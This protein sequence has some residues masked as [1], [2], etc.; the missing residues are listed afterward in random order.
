MKKSLL[1]VLI[2][3]LLCSFVLSSCN[4]EEQTQLIESLQESIYELEQENDRLTK[5]NADK[6]TELSTLKEELA[7]LQKEISDLESKDAANLAK[8]SE[9]N[10]AYNAKVAEL[11]SEKNAN[12]SALE[13]LEAEYTAAV[14][15]LE[16]ENATL[17]GRI[18]ELEAQVEELINKEDAIT[19][20]ANGYIVVNGVKTEYEVEVS[21]DHVW[22]TT[23]TPPTCTEDGWD[24]MTC[25]FCGKTVRTNIIEATLHKFSTNYESDNNYHWL[26]C[27]VCGEM[28][29]QAFHTL[30]DEGICTVCRL[31]I[32]STPGIVYAISTDGTYAE[33]VGYEGT[34]TKIKIADTYENLPVKVVCKNAF[35]G[36]LQ[37]IHVS[38]GSNIT[39]IELFAFKNCSN[40]KTVDFPNGLETIAGDAFYNAGLTAVTIP[41]TV[42]TLGD[43]AFYN[44]KLETV[45]IEEGVTHVSYPAFYGNY[46]L[47]NITLPNSITSIGRIA[48]GDPK[49][50]SNIQYS[51][52]N[53]N[54][55]LGNDDNPYL[56]LMYCG[57]SSGL[58][59]K[60][61]K[62]IAYGAFSNVNITSIIIPSKVSNISS[63]AFSGCD[64]L[65]IVYFEGTEFEWDKIEVSSGNSYLVNATIY[66]YSEN[67]PNESGNYWHYINGIPTIWE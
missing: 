30:N 32:S 20:D 3:S 29:S 50:S 6:D 40:L 44:C 15:S 37:I 10:V 13:A 41:G 34:A 22:N 36:N 19:V 60:D 38:F 18:A 9:L 67:K 58:I 42:K 5:E 43:C 17:N 8:I 23:T 66:Y 1:L 2:L 57:N 12:A 11:E 63:S 39:T 46:Y 61:T 59:H 51:M 31:P 7:S 25:T 21:C 65:K 14:E 49:Y 48:F 4:N 26:L 16:A 64:R 24:V 35:Y 52:Y 54:K 53:G 27:N 56:V 62:V 47:T 45:I 55:Y 28:E 33:V